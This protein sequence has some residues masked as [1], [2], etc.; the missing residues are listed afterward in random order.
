MGETVT[1][2]NGTVAL[3]SGTL[4]G[5]T[6]TFSTTSLNAGPHSIAAVYAGDA[7][8]GGS[9]AVV[10]VSVLKAGTTTAL[11]VVPSSPHAGDNVNLTVTVSS[12][13][14]LV[15]VGSVIFRD[16]STVLGPSVPL[17]NTGTATL[18]TSFTAGTHRLTATYPAT[19]DFG[20]SASGVIK[21]VVQP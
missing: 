6:A 12:P 15:P 14:G 11:S 9:K 18:T 3:G 21:E 7:S 16:G 19:T 20:G 13:T 5:G 10:K 4:A 2:S 17:D 1:F 8:L